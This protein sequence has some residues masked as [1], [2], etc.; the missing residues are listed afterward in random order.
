LRVRPSVFRT[1][2]AVL[3]YVIEEADRPSMT[4]KVGLVINQSGQ[5]EEIALDKLLP[6]RC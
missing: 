6:Q 2:D 5:R 1:N 4:T 3:E